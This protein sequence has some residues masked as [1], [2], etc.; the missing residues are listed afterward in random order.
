MLSLL[1]K[2]EVVDCMNCYANEDA[3]FQ[4]VQNI[5]PQA[6]KHNQPEILKQI[7]INLDKH[8]SREKI[9]K[10]IEENDQYLTIPLTYCFEC[11]DKDS[12]IGLLKLGAHIPDD[13]KGKI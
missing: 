12:C 7:C 9:A 2:L 5:L 6:A 10:L 1:Q 4:Y 11:N 3:K 13:S 8:F